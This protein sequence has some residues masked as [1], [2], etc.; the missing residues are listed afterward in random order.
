[1]LRASFSYLKELQRLLIE[2]SLL[3]ADELLRRFRSVGR[4][5]LVIVAGIFIQDPDSRVDMIV[6]GERL[7]RGVLAHAVRSIEAELG[8]E[9]RYAAFET[10]EFNYR[11]GMYDK[12]VRDI[13]DYPHTVVLDRLGLPPLRVE[14]R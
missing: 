3:K 9:L 13:L 10:D 1:M 14:S 12:L 6:V 11:L 7:K 2:G 8:K 5:K 4:L